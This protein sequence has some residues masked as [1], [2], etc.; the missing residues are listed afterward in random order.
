MNARI[1]LAA[2]LV[3][4]A[5]FAAWPW[6][7]PRYHPE[8][9]LDRKPYPMR[10]VVVD[11]PPTPAGVDYF[12][13]ITMRVFI[14]RDGMVDRVEVEHADVPPAFIEAAVKAFRQARWEPARMWGRRVKA[15][16]VVAIDFKPPEGAEVRPPAR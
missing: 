9:E 16:K 11:F 12:G 6:L 8:P 5:L 1:A 15:L 2:A 7:D 4:L 14:G 13:R 10:N 3:A